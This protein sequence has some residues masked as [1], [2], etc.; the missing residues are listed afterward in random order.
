LRVGWIEFYNTLPFKSA[1]LKKDFTIVKGVPSFINNL[2]YNGNVDI[3]IISSGEYIQHFDKYF[4]LPDISISSYKDVY[5]VVLVSDV[6][7]E[8]IQYV[9]LSKDSKTSN[10]LIQV[11]FNKFFQRKIRFGSSNEFLKCGT[12]LIGNK[13]LEYKNRYKYVYDLSK[14]WFSYTKL[15]FVFALWCVR[16]DFYKKHPQKVNI[17]KNKLK[18]S[19]KSFFKEEVSTYPDNIKTYL[20]NLDFSLT[21][22]HILSLKLFSSYLHELNLIKDL[23]E[24]NFI[25]S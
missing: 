7:I 15:P 12:V 20:E 17:F 19:V 14:I 8:D 3:G 6:P 22:E 13:A 16:K 18:S 5:S 25:E 24:F 23:P 2:I 11:I 4:I 21:K 10:F 9:C 1:V